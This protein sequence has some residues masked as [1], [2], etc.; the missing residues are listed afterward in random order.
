MPLPV[1]LAAVA[2]AIFAVLGAIHVYWALGGRRGAAVS[3]PDAWRA[4][5][6]HAPA[7]RLRPTPLATLAVALALFAAAGVLL[8]RAA[9]LAFLPGWVYRAGTWA[10]ALLFLA[11]AMGDFRTV[12]FFKTRRGSPFATWDTRLF[13]PLCLGIAA[14]A[15]AVAWLAP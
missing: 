11:R 14:L 13:S 12:G 6:A 15:G 2:A 1:L 7:R 9:A 5:P 8:G 4:G 3:F 10:L